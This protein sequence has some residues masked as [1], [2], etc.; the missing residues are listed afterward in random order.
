[1]PL[2]KKKHTTEHLWFPP[3]WTSDWLSDGHNFELKWTVFLT[4]YKNII[5]SWLPAFRP[6]LIF[7][8]KKHANWLKQ[9]LLVSKQKGHFA[10]SFTSFLQGYRNSMRMIIV[11]NDEDDV[12]K[13]MY[14]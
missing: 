10:L 7:L 9:S 1:M 14:F 4:I 5:S 13:Q 6:S 3:T 8:I 2:R 11:N 12:L